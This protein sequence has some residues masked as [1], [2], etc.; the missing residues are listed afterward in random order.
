MRQLVFETPC[1]IKVA[2]ALRPDN[3]MVVKT[4]FNDTRIY[5]NDNDEDYT[6]CKAGA[7]ML[8]DKIKEL[9]ALPH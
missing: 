6:L 7:L 1:G 3:S 9:Y 2:L 8:A 5:L 4:Y